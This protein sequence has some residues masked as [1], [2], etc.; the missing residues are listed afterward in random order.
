MFGFSQHHTTLTKVFC[1]QRVKDVAE[2]VIAYL[3]V[4]SLAFAWADR[5]NRRVCHY[6]QFHAGTQI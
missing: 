6:I 1:C 4:P 5:N 3:K 2:V